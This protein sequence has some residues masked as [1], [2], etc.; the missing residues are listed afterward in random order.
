[1]INVYIDV[2]NI[3]YSLRYKHCAA[4]DY[5]KY[6]NYIKGIGRVSKIVAY[7]S[8]RKA[9]AR[10]FIKLLE[11]LGIEIKYK[12]TKEFKSAQGISHKSDWDV[13]MAIDM[14]EDTVGDVRANTVILG[15]ADSDMA[16]AVEALQRK[17]I[18]VIVIATGIS[19]ELYAVADRC[20]E[21]PKSMTNFVKEFQEAKG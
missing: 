3:Y 21:I 16:P 2:S 4:L 9:E 8:Q 12:K 7:G 1:M 10:E 20:I 11:K 6:C 13:G 19:T 14:L 17:G 15:S 5:A 18:K